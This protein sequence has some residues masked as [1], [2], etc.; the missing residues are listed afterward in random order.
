MKCILIVS[1]PSSQHLGQVL[2][3][4]YLQHAIEQLV[5]RGV[6]SLTLVVQTR[7]QEVCAL[8]GD[9]FRWGVQVEYLFTEIEPSW[10]HIEAHIAS[11]SSTL[12]LAGDV[13]RLPSLPQQGAEGGLDGAWATVYFEQDNGLSHWTGWVLVPENH[14]AGFAGRIAQGADWRDALRKCNLQARKV[15]LDR[16]CL[17][18]E[19]PE[20]ILNSNR[21]ALEGNFPGLF[22]TGKELRP[23]VWVARAAKVPRSVNLHAPCYVGEETWLG[24]NC[25]IGPH[26]VVGPRC[27]V[28][29]GTHISCSVVAESTYLGPELE[30]SDSYVARERIHNVRIGA[31]LEITEPH[32][33]CNLARKSRISLWA[34]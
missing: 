15:F 1:G 21:L 3:R 23:G 33:A 7:N 16:P 25:Q 27:V 13:R 14:L 8:L 24:G 26:A 17:S 2:D 20:H 29:G 22:F 6:T 11:G 30:I 34:R 31:E 9:G 28:A 4:P 12:V 10:G 19:S 5:G 18:C 32:V